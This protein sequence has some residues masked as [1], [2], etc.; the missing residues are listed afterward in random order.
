MLVEVSKRW[1]FGWASRRLCA[2]SGGVG[3]FVGSEL[4][5]VVGGVLVVCV[6]GGSIVVVVGMVFGWVV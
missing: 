5:K 4:G 1:W 3:C 6:E 2:G